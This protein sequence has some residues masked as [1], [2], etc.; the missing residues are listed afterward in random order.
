MSPPLPL[1]PL[2]HLV[3]AVHDLDLAMRRHRDQGYQVMVG[4]KHPGRLSHNALVIFEDGSYFELIAWSTDAPAEAW[5]HILQ[6]Q[7]EGLIDFALLPPSTADLV[8]GAQARGLEIHGP[9]EGGRQRPDGQQLHWTTARQITRDL[10]F[11][12][13]DVT[14]RVWRVPEGDCRRHPNGVR[15]VAQVNVSVRDL[16]TSVRR[17]RQ[18]MGPALNPEMGP[19]FARLPIQGCVIELRH[20]PDAPEGPIGFELK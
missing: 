14:P 9:L 20:H 10:P 11:L 8:Q 7:G 3:I 1:M 17:Y 18:F 16:E 6:Q 13:G 5:W 15:G 4:G 12:C 19:G 2:D